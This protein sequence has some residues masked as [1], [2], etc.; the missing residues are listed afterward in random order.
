[1]TNG[2]AGACT[3]CEYVSPCVCMFALRVFVQVCVSAVCVSHCA[4]TAD[5]IILARI[6]RNSKRSTEFLQRAGHSF[7]CHFLNVKTRH[8]QKR[9]LGV[10][11][12]IVFIID[13]SCQLF[14]FDLSIHCLVYKMPKD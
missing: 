12:T 4:L 5:W 9:A 10:Q 11:I 3:L 2:G 13:K 6:T 1:M 7:S 8:M 14:Y